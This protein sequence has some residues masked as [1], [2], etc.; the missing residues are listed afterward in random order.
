MR[1]HDIP[2]RELISLIGENLYVG[3]K[4]TGKTICA[5]HKGWSDRRIAMLF[6][7]LNQEN[8]WITGDTEKVRRTRRRH[9]GNI[10]RK[11]QT[12]SK[13]ELMKACFPHGHAKES[14]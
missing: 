5:Y 9:F 13:A 12:Q 7:H 1:K 14:N 2:M 10:I 8:H 3:K 6:G 11:P 4:K